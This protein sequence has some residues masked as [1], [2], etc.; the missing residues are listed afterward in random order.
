MRLKHVNAIA[1]INNQF[2]FQSGDGFLES[3]NITLGEQERASSCRFTFFDPGLKFL[4]L[5]LTQFQQQGGIY[6]P[7][8][9]LSE[10][11][12]L[13]TNESKPVASTSEDPTGYLKLLEEKYGTS[14]LSGLTPLG[15]KCYQALSDPN[16]RAFLDAIAIAEL[17][18]TA[19]ANAGGYGYLYG[20]IYGK[21]TFDPKTLNDHPRRRRTAG[22][23]TSSATGRYQTMDF[24]WDDDTSYSKTG[25]GLK[26]F[27]PIS[28]EIL[29]VSRIIYRGVLE[30]VQRGEFTAAVRGNGK[31][32]NGARWE[33]AS[34]EGNPYGQGTQT[35]KLS[36]FLA[37]IERSKKSSGSTSSTS[38]TSESIPNA[39][40][41]LSQLKAVSG[42]SGIEVDVSKSI[43]LFVGL[44]LNDSTPTTYEFILTGVSGSN[45]LPHKTT[46]SGKQVRAI[47][48]KGEKD[49]KVYG[50]TTV[51]ILAD[52]IASAIGASVEVEDE[53]R[54]DAV[55]T[56]IQR[57]ESKY[58]AL[59]K[60]AQNLGLFVRSEGTKIK[61]EPLKQN[62]KIHSIPSD[63]LMPGSKWGDTASNDR[64]I[65]TTELITTTSSASTASTVLP[66][67]DL[68]GLKPTTNTP[69]ILDLNQ[70]ADKEKGIGKGF[71]STLILQP[72]LIDD[73]YS[74]LPGEIVKPNSGYGDAIDRSYRIDNI[75]HTWQ[76]GVVSSQVAIYLPI[77]INK[78]GQSSK[79]GDAIASP[80][81][82]S[83]PD[84]N[85]WLDK[86]KKPA[87]RGDVIEG[88][89]RRV[90][91]P[92]G[93]RKHPV[94]G[95]YRL[96][97][98]TDVDC[99]SGTPLYA[100]VESGKK[101]QVSYSPGVGGAGNIVK[102][103]YKDITLLYFHLQ[104][105]RIGEFDP[106]QVIAY[107]GNTGVGTGAHLHVE[108]YATAK[109]TKGRYAIP[110]G[111][112]YWILTG[113]LPEG[114]PNT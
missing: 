94:Y 31:A 47:A 74:W 2:I 83:S 19:A 57:N 53:I 26:D 87:A 28:Q 16:V 82:A 24:V 30:E 23:L 103:E 9:L 99:P 71:S 86:W 49:F 4:N 92:F 78:K 114:N 38:A 112:L 17:G 56:I 13:T 104:S 11:K 40:E 84:F 98:G 62:A 65:S 111:Y 102:Y 106:G 21:E 33:W 55:T 46:V 109:G 25:L 107:S 43:R 22:G 7:K 75:Q 91:S 95:T 101:A 90:T 10:Q 69:G 37:N 44:G 52:Q 32:G 70:Q 80:A 110:L 59:V 68:S 36:I 50:N 113:K 45:S 15:R 12:T 58:Q 18:E 1:N 61:L 97:G 108:I 60:S 3:L 77:A 88:T 42:L 79:S 63:A 81:T 14:D 29:A 34:L 51:R 41:T 85:Q 73:I 76:G 5:F 20:D 64:I 48:S 105:G 8:N 100:I 6:I 72:L 27:K 39:T 66:S 54:A 89:G 67:V 96:H 93:M 35:G